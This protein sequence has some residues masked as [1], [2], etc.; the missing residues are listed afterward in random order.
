VA[1]VVD[2]PFPQTLRR[3]ATVSNQPVVRKTQEEQDERAQ[4]IEKPVET[5]AAV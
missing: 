2:F 4:V 3:Q 1:V 5:D